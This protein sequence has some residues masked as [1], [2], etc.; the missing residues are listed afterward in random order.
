MISIKKIHSESN[1]K[2]PID[3]PLNEGYSKIT[4]IHLKMAMQPRKHDGVPRFNYPAKKYS[5]VIVDS[6]PQSV[7]HS[8]R[9]DFQHLN[10]F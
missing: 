8:Y 1:Q 5:G 4:G 9:D 2:L 10:R 3:T 6:T 7:I